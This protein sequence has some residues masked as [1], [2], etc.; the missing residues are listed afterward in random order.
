M[1]DMGAA[2]DGSG[3]ISEPI[4]MLGGGNPARIPEMEEIFRDQLA[5]IIDRPDEFSRMMGN[6]ASSAGDG[7]F[8]QV[9][10]RLLQDHGGSA[11]AAV[12]PPDR[13]SEGKCLDFAI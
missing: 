13:Q 11:A 3:S 4:L 10:A 9:L 1:E 2:M 12:A 8:R 7:R 6:Y 5:A